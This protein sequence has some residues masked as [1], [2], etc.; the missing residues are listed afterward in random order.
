MVLLTVAVTVLLASRVPVSLS[1][2]TWK[3]CCAVLLVVIEPSAKCHRRA[4]FSL[5]TWLP[6]TQELDCAGVVLALVG[7]CVVDGAPV[8]EHR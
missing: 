6:S 2:R 4:G 7:V 8:D 5:S 3:V 1:A